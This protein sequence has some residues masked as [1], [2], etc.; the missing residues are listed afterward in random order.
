M[1]MIV[2]K[3]T[4]KIKNFFFAFFRFR[5]K[6]RICP[7][8]ARRSRWNFFRF[9]NFWALSFGAFGFISPFG[10]ARVRVSAKFFQKVISILT[11]FQVNKF[12]I[13]VLF[14][15]FISLYQAICRVLVTEINIKNT[16][17]AFFL[18]SIYKKGYK[19]TFYIHFCNQNSAY[20]LMKTDKSR[21]F[22]QK[23]SCWFSKSGCVHP[24]PS[25]WSRPSLSVTVSGKILNCR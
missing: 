23:W 5:K 12:I 22:A 20:S 14:F 2:S 7:E 17:G 1:K 4:K 10:M 8:A 3:V 24:Y 19:G 15:I 25:F 21:K 18:V 13:F 9:G 11:N 6:C 16:F